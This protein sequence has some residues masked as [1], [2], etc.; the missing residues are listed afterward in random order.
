MLKWDPIQAALV[1]LEG[2]RRL[3]STALLERKSPTVVCRLK[4]DQCMI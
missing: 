4:H 1:D 2:H 3:L